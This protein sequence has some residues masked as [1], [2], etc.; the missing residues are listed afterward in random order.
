VKGQAVR[1]ENPGYEAA[2]HVFNG[3]IDRRPAVIVRPVDAA[4]Q[5]GLLRTT[6]SMDCPLLFVAAATTWPET[7]NCR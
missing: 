1:E 3:L 7:A 6:E 5:R 2:R 4:M